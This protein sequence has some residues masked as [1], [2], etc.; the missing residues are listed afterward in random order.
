M[1]A[2]L[3]SLTSIPR[4]APQDSAGVQGASASGM[5]AVRQEMAGVVLNTSRTRLD[6][7]YLAGLQDGEPALDREIRLPKTG[8]QPLDQAL[9]KAG[10]VSLYALQG[11]S[12]LL[13]DTWRGILVGATGGGLLGLLGGGLSKLA[14]KS[15]SLKATLPIGM[16][17]G[18]SIG[19][20]GGGMTAFV[21]SSVELAKH[22][23]TTL[24]RQYEALKVDAES[25]LGG[26]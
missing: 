7:K 5:D 13:A 15:W 18:G 20:F 8:I 9:S 24:K 2:G 22:V 17:I 23:R 19:T 3:P 1:T 25:L 12:V 10:D 4:P 14:Q 16:L 11:T 6:P 21:R 26:W